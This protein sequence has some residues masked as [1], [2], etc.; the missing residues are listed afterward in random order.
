MRPRIAIV[1]RW[2]HGVTGTT[3][4]LLE[5]ARRLAAGGWEVHLY[6]EKVDAGRF[7]SAGAEPHIVPR[8]PF[9]GFLKRR[10]F[11]WKVGRE[12]EAEGFD[13]VFG[14]GDGLRQDI[15]SLHNCVHAAAQAV[16]G[17]GPGLFSGVALLHARQLR[18]RLFKRMIANSGLTKR[19]I[20]ARFGVPEE[21]ITVIYPGYDPERFN[22]SGRDALRS[23]V[24][25]R[26]GVR[27]GELLVGLITSG[28]FAKRGV[29]PFLQALGRLPEGLKTRAR[30][31]VVGAESRLGPYRRMAAESGFAERAVFLPPEREVQRFFHALDLYVHPALFEEFG[32]SVQEAMACGVPVLT[33]RRVGAAELFGPEA[34]G[35]VLDSPEPEGLAAAL[36]GLLE[37]PERRARLAEAGLKAC[38]GNTWDRNFERTYAV[39]EAV[40]PR[41]ARPA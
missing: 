1:S 9:G 35:E 10:A 2:A 21:L 23:G 32:Q 29:A 8:L 17:R 6:S 15:L 30:V 4:T 26:A 19:D 36:A 22:T 28:D 13:V 25:E 24:R 16:H 27:P 34:A 41:P 37:S 18:G 11:A 31:L 14:H 33:S 12:L 7:A 20:V 5:H 39:I 38:A 40:R 3:T